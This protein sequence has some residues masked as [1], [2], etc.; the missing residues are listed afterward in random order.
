MDVP[1]LSPTYYNL[2]VSVTRDL[3]VSK[4]T[5]RKKEQVRENIYRVSKTMRRFALIAVLLIA[6]VN[7]QAVETVKVFKGTGDTTTAIFTVEAPWVLDWNLNGDYDA[8][9]ALDVTLVE[10]HTG[11]YVGRILHTKRK[12]N[13]LQLFDQAGKFQ[14]RI[15]STLARWTLKVQQLE[16]EERELYTPRKPK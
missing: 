5:V 2:A 15:S 14:L 1:Y 9:V 7:A 11:R 16:P 4:E 12:G 13:G 3:P 8:I 6:S 10:A